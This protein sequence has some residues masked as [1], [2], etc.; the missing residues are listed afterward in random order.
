VSQ[1]VTDVPGLWTKAS[2]FLAS[3]WCDGVHE[4]YVVALDHQTRAVRERIAHLKTNRMTSHHRLWETGM[5]VY[6]TPSSMREELLVDSCASVGSRK[7]G[8]GDGYM[9]VSRIYQ[10]GA[11]A[12]RNLQCMINGC[13]V[14]HWKVYHCIRETS[15]RIAARP[16]LLP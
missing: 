15:C 6:S 9:S 8:N 11:S 14:A 1:A 3:D 16:P 10:S 13:D 4:L 7:T 5:V 2:A 12:K